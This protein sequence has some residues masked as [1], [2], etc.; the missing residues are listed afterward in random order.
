MSIR[1]IF[2]FFLCTRLTGGASWACCN[3]F[4]CDILYIKCYPMVWISDW[5]HYQSSVMKKSI[6]N[7]CFNMQKYQGNITRSNKWMVHCK[8]K[9]EQ[10]NPALNIFSYWWT[11]IF[12]PFMNP[13]RKTLVSHFF[14]LREFFNALNCVVRYFEKKTKLR[15]CFHKVL[16]YPNLFP[17]DR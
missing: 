7:S 5:V 15:I 11:R 12:Y 3:F 6:M 13:C 4:T 10:R 8:N 16:K 2:N 1:L 9:V 17:I 14:Y